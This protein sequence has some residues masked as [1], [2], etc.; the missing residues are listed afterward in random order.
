MEIFST[1]KSLQERLLS[2][3]KQEK[4]IG[5]VPTMGALHEGHISL[6]NQA[7][8]NCDYV[9]V[10][11]FVNPTQFNNA[12]DLEKYPRTLEK[13]VDLLTQSG[14]DFVFAPDPTEIYPS[15]YR[16]SQIDLG[17]LDKVM[18]G[19]FRPGHFQGVVEVV[20]RLFEIVQPN[21]ACFG[22]KD[23]QQVAVIQ[24]MTSVFNLPV[25]I[26]ECP[27][28]RNENGL[29]LSSR[30][31]RL[32]EAERQ[33]ALI[34][35]D[36]LLFAKEN[37]GRFSPKELM[38]YCIEKID[39]SEL[40]SEYVE[41]VHPVTLETLSDKWVEGAICCI[42][43]YCGEVRLIDNMVLIEEGRLKKED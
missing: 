12:S 33:Q 18:E 40:K 29:A 27:I 11:I 37:T 6:V 22:K 4:A 25:Q 16:S 35:Y 5:L 15:G 1:V 31:M 24:Y 20:K 19:K 34:L 8:K 14:V 38:R 13:D 28:M 7:K 3:K 21:I 42:A 39:H 2:L 30:N 9:V 10:S 17:I 23:F 41:I 36:T 32:S 43:A 26:I